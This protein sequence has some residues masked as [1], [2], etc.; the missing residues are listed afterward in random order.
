MRKLNFQSAIELLGHVRDHAG[1]LKLVDFMTG[2]AM[3]DTATTKWVV[4]LFPS[5]I[6]SR[7]ECVLDA[8]LDLLYC[9]KAARRPRYRIV[10]ITITEVIMI[11][12]SF[13]STLTTAT[14]YV[15]A[16]REP[17]SLFELMIE[18]LLAPG[19]I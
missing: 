14:T 1:H 11:D 13:R 19:A 4:D 7:D 10:T 3:D 17:N 12:G 16:L 2:R 8:Y 18:S 15:F 6:A 5:I 9:W